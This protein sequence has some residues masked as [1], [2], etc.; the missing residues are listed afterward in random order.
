MAVCLVS[1]GLNLT[2]LFPPNQNYNTIQVSP[3]EL[4]IR[5]KQSLTA[6]LLLA[7]CETPYTRSNTA[8]SLVNT[9]RTH[10]RPLSQLLTSQ[11][12][13]Q[14]WHPPASLITTPTLL[15][16]NHSKLPLGC[17]HACTR[18]PTASLPAVP[19]YSLNHATPIHNPI[20]ANEQTN[21]SSLVPFAG[22][23]ALPLHHPPKPLVL[24][25]VEVDHTSSAAAPHAWHVILAASRY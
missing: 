1:C 5:Y 15:R 18:T 13:S 7:H 3:L 16:H 10:N 21:T 2:C 22:V 4:S 23:S 11:R 14:P 19:A 8:C 24:V 20:L 17:A 9:Q 6:Q 25:L 12:T